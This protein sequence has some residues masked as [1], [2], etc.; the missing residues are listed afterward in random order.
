MLINIFTPLDLFEAD[1]DEGITDKDGAFY[2]HAVGG[3]QGEHLVLGHLGKLILEVEG[4]IEQTTRIEKFSYWQPAFSVPLS[5]LVERGIAQL[6]I[7][8]LVFNS[9]IVEPLFCLLAG[10]TFGVAYKFNQ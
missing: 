5:E 10:C 3:K 4:F 7:A 2:E 8:E 1:K 6:Y 9:V